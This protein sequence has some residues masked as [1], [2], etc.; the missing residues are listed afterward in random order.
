MKD[1]VIIGAGGFGRETA[2]LIEENNRVSKEWN[3]V[4]YVDDNPHAGDAPLPYPILGDTRWLGAIEHAACAVCAIA[5]PGARQQI[6]RSLERNSNIQFPS[7]ISHT[8]CTS[9]VRVGRGCIVSVNSIFTTDIQLDDFV[10]IAAGACI[11]HDAHIERY[12]TIYP[13]ACIGGT[14]TIG[15]GSEIGSGA[16]IIQNLRIGPHTILGAGAV[17]VQDIPK[18]STAVGCPARVIKLRDQ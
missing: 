15:A 9:G 16:N 6:I 11:G 2:W 5:C 8:V 7:I 14:V 13:M 17:V 18:N 10:I 3:I 1:I 12:A 4:G